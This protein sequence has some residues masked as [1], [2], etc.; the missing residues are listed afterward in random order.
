MC[1]TFTFYTSNFHFPCSSL[2]LLNESS[3]IGSFSC[4]RT[5]LGRFLRHLSCLNISQL[6]FNGGTQVFLVVLIC[7]L[8]TVWSRGGMGTNQLIWMRKCLNPAKDLCLHHHHHHHHHMQCLHHHDN[9]QNQPLV[10]GNL[11]LA[12]QRGSQPRHVPHCPPWRS[13][14]LAGF[15]SFEEEKKQIINDESAYDSGLWGDSPSSRRLCLAVSPAQC[16]R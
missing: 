11:P 13:H 10:L 5:L 3:Q 4:G 16:A 14:G 6:H 8:L 2:S 1:I 15:Y 9:H 7:H 12:L